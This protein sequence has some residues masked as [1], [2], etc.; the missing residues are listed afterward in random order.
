LKNRGEQTS[1][2][3]KQEVDGHSDTNHNPSYLSF[4]GNVSKVNYSEGFF[5]GY[6][7]YDTK[8]LDVKYPF[9]FGLSYTEFEYSNL[10]HSSSGLQ[11][12]DVLKVTVDVKNTG[13]RAGKEIVQVYVRDVK[14]SVMKADKELKGFVKVELAPGE[15]KSVQI[16]LNER[17][18]A[19][20]VEHLGRF[21]VESGEFQILVG[22]YSRDI[23]LAETVA[24]SAS[25]E[26][27]E[28]LTLLHSLQ[29]WV[30]DGRH[31]DKAKFVMTQMKIEEDSPMYPRSGTSY[32]GDLV[33]LS[34]SR[35]IICMGRTRLSRIFSFIA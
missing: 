9:G 30:E 34:T 24:F 18:F 14:S 5:V 25:E 3:P 8:K 19:H 1:E 35:H 33:N 31:A 13:N 11:D 7:Y 29:E 26:V 4:P 27:R 28:P 2:V 12:G 6:R 15:S 10:R 21:A 22:A 23:R 20:Y 16:E 17:D 32:E